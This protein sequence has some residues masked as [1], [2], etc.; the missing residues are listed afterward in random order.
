VP[1]EIDEDG[2]LE[3]IPEQEASMPH[4][5]VLADAEPEMP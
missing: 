5:V 3:A 1:E 2:P 4:E